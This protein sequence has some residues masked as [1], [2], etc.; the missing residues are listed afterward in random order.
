MKFAGYVQ[1]YTGNGKGKT[2]AAIGQA[3]RAAGRGLKTYV[4]QFMKKGDYGEITLIDKYLKTHIKIEQFGLADFHYKT[5]RVSTE[6]R[7]A[8]LKGITA[9]KEAMNSGQYHIIILDEINVLLYF[10]I[11]E[12]GHVLE[13]I[14]SR[15]KEIELILTGRYAPEEILKRADLITEMKEIKHYFQKKIKARTG[16]EK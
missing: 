16:I 9:V 11:I 15:K 10:K 1:V 14:D 4:A 2:T 7:E 12:I 8:A 6:Q 13:I 3:V 5:D